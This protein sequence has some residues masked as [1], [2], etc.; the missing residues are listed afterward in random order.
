MEL[1]IFKTLWGQTG[2]LDEA[3]AACHEHELAGVEGQAP[4][5]A[6]QRR[7]FAAKLADS[8]LDFIA[9]ICT[10]GGY[11]PKRDASIGEHL[12]SLRRQ[13]EEAVECVPLFLTI[14]GGCDAWTVEESVEFFGRAMAITEGLKI[15]ASF[16]THRSRSFFNP[17]TTR[18]ILRQLP[19]L[20]LTCDFSHWCV[21]CERLL[22]G[23]PDILA[24]CAD[25]AHHVHARVGYDQGPQVPHPS[26]PE[27]REALE[28]HERWW[29]Q[30]WRAQA[31]RG[32]EVSTMTPE[33][34]PDGYL[35]TLS[36]TGAPVAD[37]WQ[38]NAW[39][40]ERERRRFA[41]WRDAAP[42]AESATMH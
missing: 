21:V 25:R 34:G 5:N 39:M 27:Y 32:M 18:E 19:T 40:A 26:A 37:L 10:A 16:E 12:D 42:R 35:H 38:I 3:I 22:D 36:F 23:E 17:W 7:E 11:V 4:H 2:T 33:F 1:R 6:G 8:G 20:R 24:L 9:E 30:I 41:D 31:E 15:M 13:A 29:T 28:A 14:I